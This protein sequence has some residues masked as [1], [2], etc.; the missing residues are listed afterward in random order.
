MQRLDL[1]ASLEVAA[2]LAS[3]VADSAIS[4]A[5]A[6]ASSPPAKR[7]KRA[8]E[9]GTGAQHPE[10]AWALVLGTTAVLAES[11]GAAAEFGLDQDRRTATMSACSALLTQARPNRAHD[12]CA[13]RQVWRR[14]QVLAHGGD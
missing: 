6:G 7:H 11:W 10:T 3:D 1:E 13:L 8:K 12:T 5:S 9:S 14:A 2:R 4:M